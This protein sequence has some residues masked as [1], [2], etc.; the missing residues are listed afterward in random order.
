M[1][2][3]IIHNQASPYLIDQLREVDS[4]NYN[5]R[6][7]NVNLKLPMAN[8]KNLKKKFN[9]SGCTVRGLHSVRPYSFLK[10]GKCKFE[11]IKLVFYAFH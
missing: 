5:W 2:H 3:K 1:M 11:F 6:N 8:T 10:R 4:T 7:D 9:I